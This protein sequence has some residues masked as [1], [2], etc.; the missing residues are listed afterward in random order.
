MLQVTETHNIR[1]CIDEYKNE[2]ENENRI[3]TQISYITNTL[4][5]NITREKLENIEMFIHESWYE[6]K[7]NVHIE[8]VTKENETIN[9]RSRK[10]NRNDLILYTDGSMLEQNIGAALICKNNKEYAQIRLSTKSEVV[11]AET[12]AIRKALEYAYEYC[13]H[14]RQIKQVIVF[15]DSQSSIRKFDKI[16]AF[17]SQQNVIK[18]HEYAE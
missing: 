18:A 12:V 10:F 9:H 5:Q 15:S 4:Q 7:I 1:Q 3:D 11:D 8:Q 17:S 2:H 13:R 16:N 14:C 6:S